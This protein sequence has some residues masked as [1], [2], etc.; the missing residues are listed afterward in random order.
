[1]NDK[2]E[3]IT[4]I[5]EEIADISVDEMAED[6]SLVDDLDLSSLEIMSVISEVEKEFK[7]KIQSSELTS[8][9]TISDLIELIESKG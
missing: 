3:K 6:S 2:F 5:I 1:M 7:V 9:D 8:V 4:K